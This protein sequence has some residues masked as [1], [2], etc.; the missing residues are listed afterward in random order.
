MTMDA[1]DKK[2]LN[3]YCDSDGRI[4]QFPKKKKKFEVLLRYVL[5]DFEVGVHYSERRVNEILSKFN[6]DTAI[7]RRGLIEYKMMARE[8]GGGSYQVVGRSEDWVPWG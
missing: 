3:T 6:V 1:Y 7:L 8:G 2:V 5:K 4:K